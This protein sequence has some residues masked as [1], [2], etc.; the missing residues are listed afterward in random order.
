M[1]R[2]AGRSQCARHD[3]VATTQSAPTVVTV[4]HSSEP[5]LAPSRTRDSTS[6]ASSSDQPTQRSVRLVRRGQCRPPPT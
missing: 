1:R 6:A 3:S 4:A 2:A 5:K